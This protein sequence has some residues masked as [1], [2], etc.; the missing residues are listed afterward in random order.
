LARF[1]GT[2]W[3]VYTETD[4]LPANVVKSIAFAPN[5]DVWVGA[6][7]G[8]NPPY[9]GGV[10]RFDGSKWNAY[11]TANSPLPHNQV[12]GITVGADGRVWIATASEGA[13]IFTPK[14]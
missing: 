8:T 4:G 5:G 6:F 11:T 2:D 10:G 14:R 1:D 7:D 3:T 12:E 9:H 13:A